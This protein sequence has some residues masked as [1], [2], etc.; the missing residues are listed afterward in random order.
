VVRVRAIE[1]DDHRMDQ[2]SHSTV[3]VTGTLTAQVAV[4]EEL[5]VGYAY[6]YVREGESSRGAEGGG[7]TSN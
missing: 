2:C 7:G 6:A 3:T 5:V 1:G 4:S